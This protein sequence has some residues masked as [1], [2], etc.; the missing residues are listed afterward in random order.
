MFLFHIG[1]DPTCGETN[2]QVSRDQPLA[3]SSINYP[4]NYPDIQE[5][6][7]FI[8]GPEDSTLV[9]KFNDL[10]IE[11]CCDT[12]TIGS[13]SDPLDRTSIVRQLYGTEIGNGFEDVMATKM[14]V[15]FQ[16]DYSENLQGFHLEVHAVECK[17][18]TVVNT[19]ICQGD[20]LEDKKVLTCSNLFKMTD[21]LPINKGEKSTQIKV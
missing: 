1:T 10:G 7:W 9:V 20:P 16:S 8:E 19:N 15:R 14:W 17:L 2:L 6:I 21:R 13:G 11:E 4:E 12:L 18:K 3:L 5:C